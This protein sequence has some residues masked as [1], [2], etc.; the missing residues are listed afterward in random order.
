LAPLSE[1][2][3]DWEG[4]LFLNHEP[5]ES[6]L[7]QFKLVD[8]GQDPLLVGLYHDAAQDLGLYVYDPGEPPYP[9]YLDL[10]GYIAL[11]EYTLLADCRAGAVA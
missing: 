8:T 4:F 9:L 5:A 11:L 3:G 6:R 2:Y 7:H 1:L 10:P